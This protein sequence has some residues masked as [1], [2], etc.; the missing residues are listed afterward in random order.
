MAKIF[1]R[2]G[3]ETIL[4]GF[5]KEVDEMQRNGTRVILA[6]V[7]DDLGIEVGHD[8]GITMFQGFH[9]DKL[10]SSRDH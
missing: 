2:Q 1:W 9:I 8:L 4:P 6:R 10:L 7:D 3:A 5:A